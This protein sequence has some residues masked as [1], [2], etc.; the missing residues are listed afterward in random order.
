MAFTHCTIDC[1]RAL[2]ASHPDKLKDHTKITRIHVELGEAAY[3]HGGFVAKRPITSIGA[4]MSSAYVVAVQIICGQV[5]PAQFRSDQLERDEIWR[6]VDLT[7]CELNKNL[8]KIWHQR[9]TIQFE[10]GSVIGQYL[11]K[12]KGVD[13]VITNEEIVEKYRLVLDGVIDEERRN[14]IEDFVLNIEKAKEI[15]ELIDLLSLP[16]KNPIL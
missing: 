13:P 12:M 5:L 4:Q 2:Q 1:I 8:P 15:T 6:L 9:V 7:S 3:H 10:D 11:E 14:K 16:T